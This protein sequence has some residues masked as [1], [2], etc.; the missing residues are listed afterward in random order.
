MRETWSACSGRPRSMPPGVYWVRALAWTVAVLACLDA[1]CFVMLGANP[2]I[3]SDD[4]YS[5]DTFVRK[6][7]EGRLGIIDFFARRYDA[8]HAQPLGKLVMLLEWHWFDLDLAVGSVVGVLAATVC[9]AIV[10]RTLLSSRFSPQRDARSYLAWAAMCAVLFS[11]N[12]GGI[13]TWPLVALGYLLIVPILLFMLVVWH[14]WQGQ[15]Y[16][17]LA[18]ATVLLGVVADDSAVVVVMSVMV[19]LLLLVLREPSSSRIAIWKAMAV[20]FAITVLVRIGYTFVP[21]LDTTN[22]SPSLAANLAGLFGRLGEGEAW[23]WLMLPLSLSVAFENPFHGL[24]LRAWSMVQTTLAVCLVAAH[25]MFWWR[26]LRGRYNRPMFVAVCLMLL[27][28]GWVAAII[29]VRVPLFGGDYVSQSRYVLVYQLN[30]IALLLMWAGAPSLKRL[31]SSW[32]HRL[33]LRAPVA[34]CVLL[35]LLQ[36]PLAQAAW[37]QRRYSLPYYGRMAAQIGQ[38][39]MDPT[40]TQGCLPEL[41]VCRWPLDRRRAAL[42]LLRTQRLNVFSPRVQA[43]HRFLPRRPADTEGYGP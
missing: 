12:S 8:D 37:Q 27:S 4:W 38:L 1:F 17:V 18:L 6:A 29:I 5:L 28:Y 7:V 11:L 2:V 30:L 36:I 31:A 39:A 13:W 19:A 22:T 26:A 15:H 42:D 16:G 41:V 34:G 35:L 21:V 40:Q 43:R 3:R 25:V 9:A 23:K 10:H 24:S 32:R 33:A 20:I 14:A